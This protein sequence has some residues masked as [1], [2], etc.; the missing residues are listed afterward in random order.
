MLGKKAGYTIS[1]HMLRYSCAMHLKSKGKTP[2]EIQKY[3]GHA[4]VSTTLLS[5]KIGK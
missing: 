2:D 5:W 3:L 4:S 1:P